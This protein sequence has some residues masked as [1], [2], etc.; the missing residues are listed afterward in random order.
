MLSDA[1]FRVIAVDRIGYGKS[2]KPVI[3]YNFNF[4]AANMKALGR[5]GY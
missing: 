3:P 4:V 2:S 5:A 1:G